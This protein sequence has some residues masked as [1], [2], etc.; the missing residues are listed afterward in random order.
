MR[1]LDCEG[2]RRIRGV[3]HCLDQAGS[4]L[5]DPGGASRGR[6]PRRGSDAGPAVGRPAQSHE[7]PPSQRAAA[8]IEGTVG[9]QDHLRLRPPRSALLL[10][11]GDKAG[12]WARWYRDN[13]PLAEQL[14][15]DYT[16]DEEE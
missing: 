9:D 11:G 16:A 10:L 4:G 6:P 1:G 13:I 14:Y 12:N 2:H 7:D 8:R 3:V 15:I 5:G